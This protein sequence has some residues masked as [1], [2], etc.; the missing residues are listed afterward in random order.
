MALTFPVNV[1]TRESDLTPISEE[2]L[3][4]IYPAPRLI[5]ELHG[6]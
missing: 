1:D 4:K 3:T 5:K 6:G 2:A